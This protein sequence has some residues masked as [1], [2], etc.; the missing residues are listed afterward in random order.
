M[1]SQNP[2]QLSAEIIESAIDNKQNANALQS[3][4][5]DTKRSMIDDVI[6]IDASDEDSLDEP[7]QELDQLEISDQ[8]AGLIIG[9]IQIS[10]AQ[11]ITTET[12]VS[13]MRQFYEFDT[14]KMLLV[15]QIQA[16]IMH[17]KVHSYDAKI[18]AGAK[19]VSDRAQLHEL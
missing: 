12:A 15:S 4:I 3:I 7:T 17:P 11:L 10:H 8:L 5:N 2:E 6:P 14:N 13:L 9:C 1:S 16:L 19:L 18:R